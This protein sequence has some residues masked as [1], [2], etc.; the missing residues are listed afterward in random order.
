MKLTNNQI[1]QIIKEEL[2]SV[3]KEYVTAKLRERAKSVTYNGAIFEV[4]PLTKNELDDVQPKDKEPQQNY[5]GAYLVKYEED[6]ERPHLYNEL[7][8]NQ[9]TD[10]ELQA[11]NIDPQGSVNFVVIINNPDENKEKSI[12]D[13]IKSFL[14]F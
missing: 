12:Y 4:V 10:Q 6:A 11:L 13:K 8:N 5:A 9:F 14:K 7:K 3:L 1:K 2:Q